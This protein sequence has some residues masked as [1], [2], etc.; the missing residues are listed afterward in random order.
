M[1]APLQT[2]IVS[3]HCVDLLLERA[4]LWSHLLSEQD[5]DDDADGTINLPLNSL[6]LHAYPDLD[7]NPP[8]AQRLE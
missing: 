5:A 1:A 4:S 3:R 8:M 2:S 6:E 7:S